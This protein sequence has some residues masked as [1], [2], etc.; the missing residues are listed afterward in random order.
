NCDNQALKDFY[1]QIYDLIKISQHFYRTTEEIMEE[2]IV[3]I[4]AMLKKD[5]AKA[6]KTLETHIDRAKMRTIEAIE[7]KISFWEGAPLKIP[8]QKFNKI[9]E[10]GWGKEMRSSYQ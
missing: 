7:K 2:H 5:L 6:K 1:S 9:D 4:E 3:I 10:R 8:D